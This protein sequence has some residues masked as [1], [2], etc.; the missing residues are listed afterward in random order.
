MS[1]QYKQE[2]PHRGGA[3]KGHPRY[4]GGMP[5][6]HKTAKTLEKEAALAL[7]RQKVA[8]QVELL[9][10][11]QIDSAAGIKHFF[12]RDPKTGRFERITDEVV[13][14]R[15]VNEGSEGSHFWIYTKD[16]STQA[17]TDLMNRTLGKPS[18]RLQAEITHDAGPKLE[19]LLAN[20]KRV[21]NGHDS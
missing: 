17:F 20:L 14:E 21:G 13:I 5:K 7:L 9:V 16:P 1:T 6:G 3:P 19:I 2:E 12:L 18:E 15:A 11:A 8:E 10:E 4:G